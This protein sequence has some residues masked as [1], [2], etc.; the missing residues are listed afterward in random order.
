MSVRMLY[1]APGGDIIGSRF[2]H[3]NL[4]SK[5]FTLFREFCRFTDEIREICREFGDI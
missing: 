4:K 1:G 2:E 3:H 5:D